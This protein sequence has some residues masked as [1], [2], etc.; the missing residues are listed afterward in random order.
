MTEIIDGKETE[1][2]RERV[3]SQKEIYDILNF[4]QLQKEGIEDHGIEELVNV[5]LS[6]A[7]FLGTVTENIKQSDKP[8]LTG[9]LLASGI[10]GGIG[11]FVYKQKLQDKE[12]N[13]VRE[14]RRNVRFYE[15]EMIE[16]EPV[17]QE[18]ERYMREKTIWKTR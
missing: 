15:Q 11:N 4:F 8:M 3:Y 5:G 9:T 12:E 13:K 18:D 17:S 10:A 1:I 6:I 14:K 2:Q 7:T 16:T